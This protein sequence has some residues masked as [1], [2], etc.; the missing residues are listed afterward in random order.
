MAGLGCEAERLVTSH[1][2][3][4][5]PVPEANTS[6]FVTERTFSLPAAPV[7]AAFALS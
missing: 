5:T 1:E 7:A 4:D 3:L 2:P 6:L